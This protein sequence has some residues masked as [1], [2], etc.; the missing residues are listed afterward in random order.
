MDESFL[1]ENGEIREE[2]KVYSLPVGRT[3]CGTLAVFSI[4]GCAF[5]I[6]EMCT[7][8]MI[9]VSSAALS[10]SAIFIAYALTAPD[11]SAVFPPTYAMA[12]QS[13][14]GAISCT[15]YLMYHF[16]LIGI[17]SFLVLISLLS[18]VIALED[19]LKWTCD[20]EEDSR[21]PWGL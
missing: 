4:I 16:V 19:F 1:P 12:W 2:Y 5:S 15:V 21:R 3:A 9:G 8:G 17:S 18:C 14:C 10:T 6:S 11:T 20:R 13:G 7:E